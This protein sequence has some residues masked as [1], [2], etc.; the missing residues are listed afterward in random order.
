MFRLIHSEV[1]EI[2]SDALQG[3]TKIYPVI[4]PQNEGLPACT[5]TLEESTRS[6]TNANSTTAT[7]EHVF[8]ILVFGRSFK[9]A[10]EITIDLINTIDQK[11]SNK[12]KILGI[13]VLSISDAFNPEN[14]SFVK[15]IQCQFTARG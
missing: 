8:T 9:E 4:Y 7:S 14:N 11:A 3:K 15:T 12:H 10:H 6:V 2:L 13:N 5:Y 1:H